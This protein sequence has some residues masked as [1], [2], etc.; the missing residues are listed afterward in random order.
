[1]MHSTSFLLYN[2]NRCWSG[3]ILRSW[4]TFDLGASHLCQLYLLVSL[5]QCY[6][7]PRN[8]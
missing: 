2:Y 7:I 4:L 8:D 3:L 1:M 5:N 6:E